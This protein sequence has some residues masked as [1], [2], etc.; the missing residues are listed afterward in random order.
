MSSKPLKGWPTETFSPR[1]PDTLPGGVEWPKISVVTPSLNQGTY[2]EDNILSVLYQQY[3]NVEHIIVDGDSRD[4]TQAILAQYEK[5]LA[6]VISEPD[7]GQSEAINKGFCA[8]S[9]EILTWLNA[10]DMLAP[11]AL[12]A[13]AMA[14][15]TSNA[16][17][18]AGVCQ[19]LRDGQLTHG[20]LTSCPD[21]ELPLGELLNLDE[22]WLKGRFFHQPEVMFS[23]KIWDMAGAGV[24][25][26]LYWSMDYDL[27]VRFAKAGATMH[28]IGK[29]LAIFRVHEEQK[30]FDAQEYIPELRQICRTHSVGMDVGENFREEPIKEEFRVVLVNDSGFRGGAGIAHM[31]LGMALEL[32]GHTVSFVRASDGYRMFDP[33]KVLRDI[34]REMPDIVLVGNLHGAGFDAGFIARLTD[35]WPTFVVLHDLW[36]ITGRCAYPGECRKFLSQCD[37]NCPTASEYPA[38]PP[39][40]INAAWQAKYDLMAQPKPPLLLANSEWTRRTAEKST[41]MEAGG[42]TDTIKLAYPLDVF[43]PKDKGESRVQLGLP[44]NDFIVLFAAS[45]VQEKRKGAS[46]LGEALK[47]LSLPNLTTVCFGWIRDLK[48]LPTGTVSMGYLEDPEKIATLFA[49]ADIFVGPSLE[50]SFGQVFV[51]AAACGTPSVAYS[52]GGV[53]EA[54]A[55]GITGKLVSTVDPEAL[56]EAIRFL[57]EDVEL[58]CSLGKW[59]RLFVD[60]EWSLNKAYHRF[61]NILEKHS[62]NIGLHPPRHINFSIVRGKGIA[63]LAEQAFVFDG[64]QDTAV[65]L[66]HGFCPPE[67]PFPDIGIERVFHWVVNGECRFT[68]RIKKAGYFTFSVE[69]INFINDQKV[70]IHQGDEIREVVT[71]G[72]CKDYSDLRTFEFRADM[73]IGIFDWVLYFDKTVKE[74]A[75]ERNLGFMVFSVEVNSLD[76]IN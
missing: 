2:L 31:R 67:G 16:D 7:N 56:S 4:Q 14:F 50:E 57:Y 18:V 39:Q 8:A 1:L 15:H 61:N 11:G 26:D 35:Q 13:V 22:Y 43:L 54:L 12:A 9:G 17:L 27:W 20:H 46:H 30:T 53:P 60:N 68:H 36:M 33:D 37:E 74:Q 34:S 63:D 44:E 69:Y 38:L 75:G 40:R 66:G 72:T 51:E 23:R 65:S 70:H 47:R 24:R 5:R 55:D 21:G 19:L 41:I 48:Q 64:V 71:L 3:P 52:I 32:A 10:D 45:D 25:E 42:I 62:G 49:A 6:K 76:E 59:G 28:V 73:G 58:R 29:P